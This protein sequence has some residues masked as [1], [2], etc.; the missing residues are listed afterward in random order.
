MGLLRT[1]ILR[2]PAKIV[3]DS[4]TLWSPDDI[5]VTIDEGIQDVTT[6]MFGKVDGLVVNPKMTVSFTP[7]SFT[8]DGTNE[9]AIGAICAVL[10]PAIFTNGYHGTAYIGAG[11]EKTLVIWASD[12]TKLTLNNAVITGPPSITFA[13][14]K[15]IFGS[16]TVTGICK[17]TSSDI[18]LGVANAIYDLQA[19]QAD[20]GQA[21][22]GVPS[23]LQRRYKGNLGSQTGFTE[24][25]PE[26]GWTV[27][28]SPSWRERTVQGLTVDF[29]LTGMEIMA[30]CTPVGPTMVQVADL[31]GIGGNNG[32]S[33]GQGVRLSTQQST[34]DLDITT[35]AGTVVFTL[36]KPVIRNPGFRFGQEVLR[37]GELGFHAQ[38]RFAAGVKAA[39][40][41]WT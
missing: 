36:N 27:S 4:Q 16:M 17:T 37:T 1:N 26:E 18:D 23:Y 7:H 14:D 2:G 11:A 6:S 21:F 8:P 31:H 35:A 3:Y 39:L 12:G 22:L 40:A 32:A 19:G 10:V 29:E 33:W 13:A 9:T 5:T 24:I 38:A 41:S 34:H 20:P 28:F 30:A 15:P 25:W